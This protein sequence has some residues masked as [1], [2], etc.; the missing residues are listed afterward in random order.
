[1]NERMKWVFFA[2]IL[3]LSV[4]ASAQ[5]FPKAELGFDYSYARFAPN[6]AGTRGHSL[7]GG[8]GTLVFNINQYLG[9]KADLQGYGSTTTT[10]VFAPSLNFPGGAV[11]NVQGNLFT[12]LFGP[13]IKVRTPRIQPFVHLLFGGAHS[14]VYVNAFKNICSPVSGVCAFSK[15]PANNA[16]AMAFGGGVDIP[17]G[18]KMNMDEKP[19]TV[20]LYTSTNC[21]VPR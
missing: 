15:A 16:F 12:Y 14:N 2:A 8:G 7:N 3:L 10:F 20:A 9:I 17:I 21:V 4:M 11:A 19:I 1:M 6:T 5:E 13:Q 18:P